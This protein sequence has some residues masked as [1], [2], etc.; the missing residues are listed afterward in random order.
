VG[1]VRLDVAVQTEPEL[2]IVGERLTGAGETLLTT[3]LRDPGRRQV[4]AA[5][6]TAGL[7][8]VTRAPL[9]DD[10]LSTALLP[11]RVA[12]TTDG[13]R[14]V[15]A[16]AEQTIVALRGVFTVEPR[17]HRMRMPVPVRDGMLRKACD[18]LSAVLHRT[19]GECRTRHAALVRAMRTVCTGPVDGLTTVPRE[20]GVLAAV[21][22]GPLGLIPVDRLGDGELRFLALALVL[23]TGPGVLEVD[24]SAELL[25]AAQALT[26]LADGLDLGL[27]RAQTRELLGLAGQA[28]PR[29]HIRLLG[30]VH[31]AS[32]ADGMDG[33]SVIEFGRPARVP[34]QGETRAVAAMR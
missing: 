3:A 10:R 4:Q 26:V 20:A 27:D 2:R 19:E 29:G 17:P 7:A 9:P 12:G 33:V 23:L 6:H 31:D 8:P 13:Q 14:L 5:W 18:N 28:A 24:T 34:A 1:P 22:R 11:L 30:T 16:A 25:P 32:V 21:D 15:L